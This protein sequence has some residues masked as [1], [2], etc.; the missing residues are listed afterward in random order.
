MMTN[1]VSGALAGTFGT[2]LNTPPDV[3]KTRIQ[4]QDALLKPGQ[5]RKYQWA[6]PSMVLVAKEEG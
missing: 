5:P 4:Q 2:M 1:F 6:I 3:V